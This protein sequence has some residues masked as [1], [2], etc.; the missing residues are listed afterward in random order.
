MMIVP[1]RIFSNTIGGLA[2]TFDQIN[3]WKNIWQGAYGRSR[4]RAVMASRVSRL[5]E[6]NGEA[7]LQDYCFSIFS[8]KMLTKV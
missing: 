1:H 4:W 5:G 6:E 2:R 8:E 7:K 3:L